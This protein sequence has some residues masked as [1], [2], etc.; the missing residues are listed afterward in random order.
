MLSCCSGIVFWMVRVK[1]FWLGF[2]FRLM[3]NMCQY[4]FMRCE[5]EWML[6]SV[7]M[8]RIRIRVLLIIQ[9]L[10]L[11][12]WV[13]MFLE[14][15]FDSIR[16][17][18]SGNMLVLFV[19][20][21]MFSII[22]MQSGRNMI[23]LKNV[24]FIIKEVRF[25]MLN[26]GILKSVSGMMV[27]GV[28]CLMNRKVI[29]FIRLFVKRLMMVE[30]FQVQVVLFQVSVSNSGMVVVRISVVFQQLIL[31][32]MWCVSLGILEMI[33]NRVRM[34]SGRLVQK[35]QCQE[36]VLVSQLL[37]SGFSIMFRL[38]MVL[39]R[40]LNLVC[41]VGLN[42]LV[43]MVNVVVKSVVLLK[44]VIVWKVMS[45]FMLLLRKLFRNGLFVSLYSVELKRKIRM[46]KIRIGLWL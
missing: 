13:M 19:V 2:R 10:Y 39:N 12:V 4:R 33:R 11:L 35:V 18:I 25:L 29:R 8:F 26:I 3:M 16:F 32:C 6:V 14:V 9:G 30:L 1:R 17:S 21:D 28:C 45:W 22:C 20:G 41:L 46:L 42:M 15:M 38:K 24:M 44:F 23:M 34:F 37:I 31:F 7:Y 5:F 43:R 27:L 40:L 36:S